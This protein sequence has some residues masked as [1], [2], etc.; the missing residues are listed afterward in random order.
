[1]KRLEHI[2]AAKDECIRLG[3]TF[4]LERS[5]RHF[6]G[7]VG[8]NGKIRKTSLSVSPSDHRVNDKVRQFIRRMIREM[9]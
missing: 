3:A 9:E 1:M 8:Y 5:K 7:I 6:I 4:N 2:E